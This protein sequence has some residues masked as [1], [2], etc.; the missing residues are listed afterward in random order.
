MTLEKDE[1]LVLF[2]EDSKRDIE[3]IH[4]ILLDDFFCP[5]YLDL[6]GTEEEF[7]RCIGNKKYDVI[8]ADYTLPSFNAEEALKLANSICPDIPFI[9]VSGTI[10]ED[11]AVELLHQ[12]AAD[13]VLKDRMGRLS[14]SITRAIDQAK[15]AE[16]KKKAEQKLKQL[17][18]FQESILRLS[19]SFINISL[20]KLGLSI[21]R[22]IGLLCEYFHF[23]ISSIW[24]FDFDTKNMFCE[25]VWTRD[26]V[27]VDNKGWDIVPLQNISG[28]F[29]Y[30]NL[31]SPIFIE[32]SSKLPSNSLY[33]QIIQEAGIL[34]LYFFP[35]VEEDKCF[36]GI[37]FSN[38]EKCEFENNVLIAGQ[39]FSSILTS[40]L[41]R[42]EQEK[43]FQE[44]NY[45][46][47]L[48][49][50][51]LNEGV[52]MYE[53]D[54]TILQ[55]N[56]HFAQR[57]GKTGHECIGTNIMDCMPV[58]KY[59]DLGEKTLAKLA[60]A[61]DEA[62]PVIFE[63]DRAGY[64]FSNCFYPVF[65]DGRV[66]AVTLCS[67][68][69]TDRIK[70]EHATRQNALLAKEVE[71]SKKA[72][73]ELLEILDGSADGSCIVDY[74]TGSFEYSEKWLKR[75]GAE[76]ISKKDLRSYVEDLIHPD[77]KEKTLEQRESIIRL[78]KPR[79][80][81]EYRI[82]S[83]NGDVIWVLA[84]GK[85]IYDENGLVSKYYGTVTDVTGRKNMELMLIKQTE[86][87]KTADKNKN[88]FIGVL[89]HEL[90]NPIAAISAA[91][92]LL[93]ITE[94]KAQIVKAKQIM[95]RQM[96]QLCKLV[97]DLLD[98]TRINQNKI[99]LKK[100][101]IYLNEIVRNVVR[102]LQPDYDK[103]GVQLYTKIR[104][105]PV[106][107]NA[108]PVRIAQTIGNILSNSL[109]FTPKG[110]VVWLSLKVE[111]NDAV[112]SVED[113]GIGMSQKTLSE[114][115]RPFIQADHTLN[116]K[117]GGLGLGLSI[118]KGIVDLHGG[119]VSA[120][121]KG[122]GK[123]SLFVIRLPII[124]EYNE[125]PEKQKIALSFAHNKT[126]L[127]IE[128]NDDL[129]QA[130]SSIFNIQDHTIRV[131]SNGSEGL[132]AAKEMRPDIIFCD[133]GL[134]DMN[135]YEVAKKIREDNN[136]K[137]VILIALTGYAGKQD[138]EAALQSGF[139]RHLAKP[140]TSEILKDILSD[141][142]I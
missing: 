5:V 138:I 73:L 22:A 29:D 8:L 33:Y 74:K 76:F 80:C 1:L 17:L 135:G 95:K 126:I 11:V 131:A 77:D 83:K 52:S 106:F 116:R 36:G 99:K 102:D 100:E 6:A 46:N 115:F 79:L 72:E 125:F 136:L 78:Q 54:G 130:L 34:S 4:Q 23:D 50:D 15:E 117:N 31:R 59:G 19:N 107:L 25:Y 24:R 75:I 41:K 101:H 92:A 70:A 57:F 118:V 69:I 134:P 49:L 93:D 51:S 127:I 120:Y 139:N 16:E 27:Q 39:L 94:S 7:I 110:C 89:S 58:D 87:L 26:R 113:N 97:D 10:G 104:K 128:D 42:A 14:F 88:D 123:G 62:K 129:A 132:A 3:I 43:A 112:I 71:I 61:Y 140:V 121:S 65:K 18:E 137:N 85:L 37:I 91:L 90:R 98:L 81:L 68:D 28:I 60:E 103:R 108:D 48:I 66:I 96:N 141:I 35:L 13:Y 44:A 45:K 109:K 86:E 56:R 40:V 63:D 47:Q 82:K 32:D 142:A 53:R 105:R 9:C 30:N 119:K 122:L 20:D 55:V 133:I 21:T 67:S 2:L 111:K 38:L 114:L 64:W 124:T 84:Q 12:G